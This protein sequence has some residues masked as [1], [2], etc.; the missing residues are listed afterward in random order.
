MRDPGNEV[1][2]GPLCTRLC[3]IIFPRTS[4]NPLTTSSL[5]NTGT[6]LHG[7]PV[8]MCLMPSLLH[9]NAKTSPNTCLRTPP[10]STAG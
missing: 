4:K 8:N 3:E 6:F 9:S 2:P 10:A 7:S 5:L 1:D